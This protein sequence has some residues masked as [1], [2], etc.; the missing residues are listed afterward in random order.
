MTYNKPTPPQ[1]APAPVILTQD[2]DGKH[3]CH[4]CFFLDPDGGCPMLSRPSKGF[5]FQGAFEAI[6]HDIHPDFLLMRSFC[7]RGVYVVGGGE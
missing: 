5:H 3:G 7:N 6:G 4:N 1:A 2:R